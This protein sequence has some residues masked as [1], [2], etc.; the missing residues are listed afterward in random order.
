MK[1]I[2]E[3]KED[4]KH[5]FCPKCNVPLYQESMAYTKEV[6]KKIKKQDKCKHK[7][8]EETNKFM[9]GSCKKCNYSL[10]SY[11]LMTAQQMRCPRCSTLYHCEEGGE[12]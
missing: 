1:I 2:K 9:L 12:G 6:K 4:S 7:Y 10:G 11:F 5:P 8:K 3:I